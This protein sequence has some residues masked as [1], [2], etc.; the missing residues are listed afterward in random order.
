MDVCVGEAPDRW[1][2]EQQIMRIGDGRKGF[3]FRVIIQASLPHSGFLFLRVLSLWAIAFL[4]KKNIHKN[5]GK[6]DRMIEISRKNL[7]KYEE[8][9]TENPWHGRFWLEMRPGRRSY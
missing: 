4:R 7:R 8:P 9:I 3:F 2:R 6:A 5:F 1:H